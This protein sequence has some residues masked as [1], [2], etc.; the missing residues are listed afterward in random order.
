LNV[1]SEKS[2]E[3]GCNPA[4]LILF[5]VGA[6]ANVVVI[7][8]FVGISLMHLGRTYGLAHGTR[9]LCFGLDWELASDVDLEMVRGGLNFVV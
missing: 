3:E 5:W 7:L 8:R 6:G 4:F 1:D 2:V 9:S